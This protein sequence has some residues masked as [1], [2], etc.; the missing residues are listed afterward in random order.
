MFVDLRVMLDRRLIGLLAMILASAVA[1]SNNPGPSPVMLVVNQSDGVQTEVEADLWCVE[2]FGSE[3]CAAADR[4]TTDVVAECDENV[5]VGLPQ[6]L[7]PEPGGQLEPVPGDDA[8]LLT[9]RDGTV[10]VSAAG[11]GGWSRAS[12]TFELTRAGEC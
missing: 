9:V 7:I 10:V 5:A 3:N 2:E 12:W 11:S 4:P 1:C 6:E 8:W